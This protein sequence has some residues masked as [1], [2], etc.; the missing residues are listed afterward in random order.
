RRADQ[1]RGRFLRDRQQ[2]SPQR[3]S[4]RPGGIGRVQW[5]GR[6]SLACLD[7]GRE[8]GPRDHPA[9]QLSGHHL[10]SPGGGPRHTGESESRMN[11]DLSNSLQRDNYKLLIGAVIPRP[12]AWVSTAAPDG[13]LNLAPFSFFQSICSNPPTVIVSVS[14][15]AD[16]EWKDTASNAFASG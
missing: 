13:R 15:R 16:G 11:I 10:C 4:A 5:A 1:P 3:R 8:D 7:L 14:R 2:L 12:I 6:L 9:N